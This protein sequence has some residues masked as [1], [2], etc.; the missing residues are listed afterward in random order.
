MPIDKVSLNRSYEVT[1]ALYGIAA[2]Q[3]SRKFSNIVSERMQETGLGDERDAVDI[4]EAS[5]HEFNS[6]DPL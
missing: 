3:K 6:S 4:Q 5:K 1:A 2:P